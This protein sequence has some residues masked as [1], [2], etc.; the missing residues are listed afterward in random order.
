MFLAITSLLFGRFSKSWTFLKTT[1]HELLKTGIDC[2][3]A[4]HEGGDISLQCKRA[5]FLGHPV[6]FIIKES[7]SN[8]IG[9]I[10]VV[11]LPLALSNYQ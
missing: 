10:L 2:S 9:P 8:H 5:F 11:K 1:D 7:R 3:K 6:Y 4:P